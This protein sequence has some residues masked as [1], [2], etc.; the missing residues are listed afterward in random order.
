MRVTR[1][2]GRLRLR[3]DKVEV[4][5]LQRLLDDLEQ[6][7]AA[8]EPD[9]VH[10]RLYPAGYRDDEKA[11]SEFRAL[12]EASLQSDRTERLE[13]CRA[14]LAAAGDIDLRDPDAGQRWIKVLNDLR[15]TAGTRLGITEDEPMDFDPYDPAEQPRVAYYWLTAVQDSLVRALMR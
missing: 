14:E 3:L 1:R 7:L 2:K 4:V 11:A 5:L 12:T 13:A 6:V 10:R 9:E 15:L 8:D